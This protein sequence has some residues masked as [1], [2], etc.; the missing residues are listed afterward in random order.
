MNANTFL[1]A[2]F[3]SVFLSACGGG[4]GSTDS[5]PSQKTAPATPTVTHTVPVLID[6]QGDSTMYGS[7]PS[8]CVGARATLDCKTPDNAPALLQAALQSTFGPDVTVFNAANP[9]SF[10]VARMSGDGT[11]YLD[12]FVQYLAKTPAQIVVM[13]WGINDSV[14]ETPDQYQQLLGEAV[15]DVRQAGKIPIL[16]EPNNVNDGK[17]PALPQIVAIMRTVAAQKG[18]KLITQWDAWNAYPGWQGVLLSTDQIH[19]SVAGYHW[20]ASREAEQIGALVQEIRAPA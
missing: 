18:V 2:G 10:L 15:D 12:T 19:P 13:N 1:A 11:H 5:A 16:E 17:H 6:A 14:M 3:L 4:G 9:G 7:E 8:Y 20:K